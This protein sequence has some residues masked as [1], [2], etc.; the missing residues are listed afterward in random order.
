MIKTTWTKEEIKKLRELARVSSYDDL[1]RILKKSKN[2]VRWKV[3]QQGLKT[4]HKN[5]LTYH[6]LKRI[7][8]YSSEFGIKESCLKYSMTKN[9][10]REVRRRFK[11]INKKHIENIDPQ[12]LN[13]F[14]R[15]CYLF[16]YRKALPR[17]RCQDF[18]S[19]A[20]IKKIE[21]GDVDM[22]I[23]N[24]Y[25]NWYY[26]KDIHSDQ[27]NCEFKDSMHRSGANINDRSLLDFKELIN[28]LDYVGRSIFFLS[29]VQNMTFD[30]IGFCLNMN[31]DM[32]GYYYNKILLKLKKN[33]K[34]K[35][36]R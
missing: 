4:R 13:D 7:F 28:H 22:S 5:S 26:L 19:Y 27:L 9:Q 8:N 2:A 1:V 14:R 32:V 10:I 6:H 11:K 21:L 36:Y 33:D 3:R 17:E 24:I 25:R 23:N 18:A 34:I 12:N 15:R 20:V 31:S 35:S 16:G 30:D 29:I